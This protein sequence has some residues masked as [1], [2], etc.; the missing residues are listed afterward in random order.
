MTVSIKQYFGKKE[1]NMVRFIGELPTF[2]YVGIW[3]YC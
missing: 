1:L 3:N 2:I